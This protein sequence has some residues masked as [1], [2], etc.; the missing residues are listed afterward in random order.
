MSYSYLDWVIAQ[1]LA[2]CELKV[3]SIV[4]FEYRHQG[5]IDNRNYKARK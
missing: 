3:E 1:L 2:N 5:I 4:E